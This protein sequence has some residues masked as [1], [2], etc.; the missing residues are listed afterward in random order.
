MTILNAM[1]SNF[2]SV[3]KTYFLDNTGTT[4]K[5]SYTFSLALKQIDEDNGG[6]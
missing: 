4:T 2:S 1:G 3:K 5:N 6:K